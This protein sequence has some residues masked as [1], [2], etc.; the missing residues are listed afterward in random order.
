ML[1]DRDL[2]EAIDA[3]STDSFKGVVWRVTIGTNPPIRPNTRGA[4]WNPPGTAAI[5][6]S[7][8]KEVAVAEIRNLLATQPVPP[9][10]TLTLHELEVDLDPVADFREAAHLLTVGITQ[11]ELTSSDLTACQAVGG[12]AAWLGRAGLLVP[13]ARADGANLVVYVNEIDPEAG[14]DVVSSHR[15]DSSESE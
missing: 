15:L 12:A 10:V 13:S 9:F 14:L 1:H 11:D 3:A 5:Y 8:D 6:T 4:R 2:L 7:L